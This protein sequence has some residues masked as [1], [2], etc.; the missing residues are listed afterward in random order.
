M[1]SAIE[2]EVA[3]RERP[4]IEIEGGTMETRPAPDKAECAFW[5]WLG[6][7]LQILVLGVLAIIGAFAASTA[8]RPGD[9]T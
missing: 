1:I 2:G 6:F 7:W 9:Y 5:S 3:E 4:G 8:D